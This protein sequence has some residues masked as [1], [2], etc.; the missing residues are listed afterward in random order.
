MFDNRKRVFV[1]GAIV[2]TEDYGDQP[3]VML[4]PGMTRQHYERLQ[5]ARESEHISP[6]IL[7]GTAAALMALLFILTVSII[8]P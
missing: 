5:Q 7:L 3:V 4:P 2:M 1:Q 6:G 8:N